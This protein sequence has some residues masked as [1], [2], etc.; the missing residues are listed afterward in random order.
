[1]APRFETS[2]SF[3]W[4]AIITRILSFGVCVSVVVLD[5]LSHA[6]NNVTYG[7]VSDLVQLGSFLHWRLCTNEIAQAAFSFL[8]NINEL[9]HHSG[10]NI[11]KWICAPGANFLLDLVTIIVLVCSC[12]VWMKFGF[13]RKGDKDFLAGISFVLTFALM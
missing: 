1:M 3:R 5:S 6:N 10:P 4:A 7:A 11:R 8:A 13:P 9:L 12:F 2:S